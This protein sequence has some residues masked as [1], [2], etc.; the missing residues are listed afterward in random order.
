MRTIDEICAEVKTNGYGA[1]TDEEIDAY[2][3]WKT[4]VALNAEEFKNKMAA[5]NA[6]MQAVANAQQAI[7]DNAIKQ[8]NATLT[9]QFTPAKVEL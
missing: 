7:A 6:A 9:S 2:M 3:S 5:T 1:L 4:D 8:Y